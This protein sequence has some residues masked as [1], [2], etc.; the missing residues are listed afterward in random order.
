MVI[1]NSSIPIVLVMLH[2][3]APLWALRMSW[4]AAALHVIQSGEDVISL[5]TSRLVGLHDPGKLKGIKLWM[6]KDRILWCNKPFENSLL[7]KYGSSVDGFPLQV[8]LFEDTSARSL[9][10]NNPTTPALPCRLCQCANRSPTHPKAMSATTAG[11]L[12][13]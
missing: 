9:P 8:Q 11:F 5:A 13:I 10:P 7:P 3:K 4:R 1:L 2:A 12:R 6:Q